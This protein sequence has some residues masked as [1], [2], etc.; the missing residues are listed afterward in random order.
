VKSQTIRDGGAARELSHV[1]ATILRM[2]QPSPV[3]AP[4]TLLWYLA[5]C[6]RCADDLGQPF[7]TED[8]RDDW[9]AEHATATGHTV[10]VFAEADGT[11]M[12]E[13]TSGMVRFTNGAGRFLCTRATCER[14]NG[15]YPSAQVALASFRDHRR[16]VSGA[17]R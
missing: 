12:G 15:P 10:H 8:E 16:T 5:A 7:A 14:W 1:S 3:T 9:A 6:H 17:P 11:I 13:H 4:V 2:T